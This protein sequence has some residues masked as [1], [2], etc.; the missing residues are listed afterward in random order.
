MVAAEHGG[1]G[2]R[3][4]LNGRIYRAAFL[5]F[6]LA[7]GIAAFSLGARPG[8]LRS[9]LAPDAFQGSSA[10]ARLNDLAKAFPQRRPGSNSDGRMAQMVA[11]DIEALGGTAGGGFAVH[12]YNFNAQTIEGEQT[13]TNVVAVRPGSTSSTPIVIVAHRDAAQGP[14]RAALSATAALLELARVFSARDTKRTIVLAS[15]SGGSGGDAGVAQLRNELPDRLDAAIVLGDLGGSV[16]RRPM[17]IPYSDG[18]GSAPLVL[19]RTV[20][21]AI[22]DQAG[23]E[24]GAPS[25]LGQLVHLMVPLTVGEQGVLDREGVPAVLAQVSGERG[26]SRN[27]PIDSERLEAMGR[28]VLSAV[29]ALDTA[30]DVTQARQ[31]G[32]VLQHQQMPQ[33]AVRLLVVMLI[34]P[35]LATGIDGLARA[36]RWGLRPERWAAWTLSCAL[37]FAATA[38]LARLLGMSGLL[39]AAPGGPLLSGALKFGAGP[40]AGLALLV[41]CFVVCWFAWGMLTRWAG[42]GTRPEPE[43]GGLSTVLVGVALALVVWFINPYTALLLVPALHVWL[44]LAAP[45][46]RPRGP[47]GWFALLGLA[48]LPVV[49]VAVF[50]SHQ[51]GLGV[52]DAV[53]AAV[54]LFAGGFVGPLAV[55]LW[56]VGFG[57]GVSSLLLALVHDVPTGSERTPE[58]TEVTI[59]G[60][61]SYAGPGS[62]G[63]TESALRR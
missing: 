54:L 17:V 39:G 1:Y 59:R 6:L 42:W 41:A 23:I 29:D 21:D 4:M 12:V 11:E 22:K 7:L 28:S 15:T 9:N 52:G 57:C 5:P 34:L 27:E 50:Y 44:V 45:G 24:A 35:V 49:V 43:V 14:S 46:L 25:A 61:L 16:E 30:P 40:A 26:P 36:R 47:L 2:S 60:P 48:A 13:L 56:S 58:P 20:E 62:L 31:N 18:Q 53:W 33:W 3:P 55:V 10:L 38:L 19:A 32:I 63:G 37:P 8:P 51:L